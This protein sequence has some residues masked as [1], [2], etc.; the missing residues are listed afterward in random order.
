MK[1]ISSLE[2]T[3]IAHLWRSKPRQREPSNEDGCILLSGSHLL[4]PDVTL[5]IE[6]SSV[7]QRI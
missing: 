1:C 6:D 2:P 5:N 4:G 3:D 7:A